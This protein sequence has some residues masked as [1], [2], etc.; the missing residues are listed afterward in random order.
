[1]YVCVQKA[2]QET[3]GFLEEKL[4]SD[5]PRDIRRGLICTAKGFGAL[6]GQVPQQNPE[7]WYY[8]P[9]PSVLFFIFCFSECL[10]VGHQELRSL[11]H[12]LRTS[13]QQLLGVPYT[14]WGN[15]TFPQLTPSL[16]NNSYQLEVC[17][18]IW[19]LETVHYLFPWVEEKLIFFSLPNW[20]IRCFWIEVWPNKNNE[21]KLKK[22]IRKHIRASIWR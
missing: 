4:H 7:L 13:G 1:M 19:L 11:R 12:S 2:F 18:Q 17:L 9:E 21:K 3:K 15:P 8:S 5:N 10:S 6:T 16:A 20:N 22:K 14:K